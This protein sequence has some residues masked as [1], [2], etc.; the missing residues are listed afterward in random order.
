MYRHIF[1]KP[2]QEHDALATLEKLNEEKA[3]EF[4]KGN[5]KRAAIQCLMRKKLYENHIEQLRNFQMR[6]HDQMIMLEGAKATT[7]MIDALRTGATA[8]KAMQKAMKID[9]VDKIMDEI[10]EQTQN[11]RMIQETLSAPTGSTAYFDKKLLN[12]ISRICI[13][14]VD[15][16]EVELEELEVVELEEGL[17]QLTTTTPTI[18]LQLNN[19]N[20]FQKIFV[21]LTLQRYVSVGR[22]PTRV[23]PVK[24]TVLEEDELAALQA[25][26][27]L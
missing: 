8:M 12:D 3:K 19:Y 18:T 27:A 20:D 4:A 14:V 15:E 9:V 10:N 23:V 25:E 6:I 21:V 17:L 7:K 26:L 16:L 22:Q 11:K 2:K 13:Y 1:R 24:A 5:N